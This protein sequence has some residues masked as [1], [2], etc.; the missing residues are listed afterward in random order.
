M[1]FLLFLILSLISFQVQSQG[2]N[3]L[4]LEHCSYEKSEGLG[5]D[6]LLLLDHFHPVYLEQKSKKKYKVFDYQEDEKENCNSYQFLLK[7]KAYHYFHVN[8]YTFDTLFINVN[9]V[10]DTCINLNELSTNYYKKKTPEA[11]LLKQ[12]KAGDKISFSYNYYDCP[13]YSGFHNVTFKAI[14]S[15]EFIRLNT[16]KSKTKKYPK[17]KL[18]ALLSFEKEV[19]ALKEGTRLE[20]QIR[21][22]DAYQVFKCYLENPIQLPAFLKEFEFN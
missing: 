12:I 7:Q 16:K 11:L 18:E 22:N 8:Q 9:L 2:K 3:Y 14:S 17:I 10:K 20:I 6:T 4:K 5:L 19:R 1:K 15:T 13:Q 21:K